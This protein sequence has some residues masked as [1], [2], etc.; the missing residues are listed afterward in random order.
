MLLQII[1]KLNKVLENINKTPPRTQTIDNE[2]DKII[3][4]IN[5]LSLGEEV[6]IKRK[7]TPYT[8]W[9]PRK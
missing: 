6:R 7:P 3:S 4:G 1:D 9:V 2:L 5:R 8:H